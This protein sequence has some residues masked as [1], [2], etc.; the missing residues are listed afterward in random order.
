M[1]TTKDKNLHPMEE[2]DEEDDPYNARIEKTGCYKE[3]E[4]LQ[5]CFYDTRDWRKCKD[6]MQAFRDCFTKNKNNAGSKELIESEK[7]ND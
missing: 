1:S 5:L 4:I 6:E 7:N 3:N 2:E